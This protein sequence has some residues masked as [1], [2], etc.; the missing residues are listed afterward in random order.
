MYWSHLYSPCLFYYIHMFLQQHKHISLEFLLLIFYSGN[1]TDIQLTIIIKDLHHISCY[2]Q[3]IL[4]C[5]SLHS[6]FYA[7]YLYL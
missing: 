1:C 7:I 3:Q 4:H 6:L 2:R 5:T